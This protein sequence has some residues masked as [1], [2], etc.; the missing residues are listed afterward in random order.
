MSRQLGLLLLSSSVFGSSRLP[1]LG[2]EE[3]VELKR[4]ENQIDVLI[5]GR[6]F[7]SYYF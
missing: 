7:T 4:N 1:V 6:P 5:R 3:A 2:S